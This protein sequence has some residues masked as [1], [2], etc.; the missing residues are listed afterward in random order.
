MSNKKVVLLILFLLFLVVLYL[1]GKDLMTFENM[2]R[3][4][5]ALRKFVEAHYRL[6]VIV[7][8]I[9]EISTAFVVP[10][11]IVLSLAGG[12]LFGVVPGAVY[13]ISGLVIG[14]SLAFLASRYL[15]GRWIQQ[16]YGKQLGG[17]NEEIGR[18][19]NNYLF[20]LRIVPILPFFL[21]NYLA[22]MTRIAF[23]PFLFTTFIGMLPGSLIYN[24]AGH[25]LGR[26]EE[27]E[28]VFSPGLMAAF[29]LL[30]LLAFLPVVVNRL[31]TRKIRERKK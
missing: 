13:S 21:V 2:K 12:F 11:A 7:F 6:A 31:K 30:T 29:I 23:K 1:I 28:D 14:A 22:G 27:I 3:N 19:G 8:L 16:R 20:M 18:Y 10:G 26:I 15:I 25:Q 4:R 5:Q 24:F 9:A 17:F